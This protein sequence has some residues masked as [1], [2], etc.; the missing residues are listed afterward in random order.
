MKTWYQRY[1][2]VNRI[3]KGGRLVEKQVGRREWRKK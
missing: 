3:K 1:Q 2:F